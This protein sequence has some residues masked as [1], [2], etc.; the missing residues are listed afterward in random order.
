LLD[1]LFEFIV[2]FSTLAFCLPRVCLNAGR[3]DKSKSKSKCQVNASLGVFVCTLDLL[4]CLICLL[5]FIGAFS[6]LALFSFICL[7]ISCL[8]MLVLLLAC[9]VGIGAR[10][11]YAIVGCALRGRGSSLK[12]ASLG[13]RRLCLGFCAV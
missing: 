13:S 7:N 1:L 12:A 11:L 2:P 6:M 5:E 4:D 10:S 3:L 8:A 9:I